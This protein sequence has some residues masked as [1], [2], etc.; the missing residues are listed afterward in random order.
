MGDDTQMSKSCQGNAVNRAGMRVG[1][2]CQAKRRGLLSKEE[3]TAMQE[4]RGGPGPPDDRG[5]A[6]YTCTHSVPRG[7]MGHYPPHLRPPSRV[8]AYTTLPG[9]GRA[10]VPTCFRPPARVGVSPH[11]QAGQ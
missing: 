10:V 6:L 7:V 1:R 8:G 4:S 11:I 9:A 2:D 3:G 5:D